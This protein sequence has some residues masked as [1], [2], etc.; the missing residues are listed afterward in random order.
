[1]LPRSDSSSSTDY[2][3]LSDLTSAPLVESRITF[4]GGGH[5]QRLPAPTTFNNIGCNRWGR[6]Q[7]AWG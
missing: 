6:G 1:M 3:D 4:N 5:W 7:A 2:Y